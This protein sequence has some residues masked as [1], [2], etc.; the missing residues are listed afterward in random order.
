MNKLANSGKLANIYRIPPS[1]PLRP[2]KKVLVKSKFYKEKDKASG[3]V[4][5]KTSKKQSYIQIFKS[6][7]EKV[8]KIKNNFPSLSSKKIKEIHKVI[9]EPKKNKSRINMI[10][11]NPSRRQ[12]I[13]PISII[14]SQKFMSHFNK[15][16]FNIN[17]ILK[18][19]KSD[20][21]ANF[22]YVGNRGLLITTNKVAFSLNLNTI[23]KYIKSDNNID[24]EDVML[25]RL[26][27][28]KLYL[29][30]LGISY[31]IEDTNTFITTDIVERVL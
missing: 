29:K 24:S 6:N 3:I 13:I 19:I 15:H 28:L 16:I 26:P 7:I 27:Q 21:I 12:I 17:S 23:E 11:K 25:P 22:I 2:S 30:I 31:L 9:N 18:N 1:I 4:L 8:I 20:V 5:K 10:T 14:N